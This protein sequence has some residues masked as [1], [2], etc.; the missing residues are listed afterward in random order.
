MKFHLGVLFCFLL[1]DGLSVARATDVDSWSPV[2]DRTLSSQERRRAIEERQ[3]KWPTPVRLSKVA[4][5]QYIDSGDLRTPGFQGIE[6]VI[7]QSEILQ[8]DAAVH[9]AG[10]LVLRELPASHTVLR[11]P[12]LR[13]PKPRQSPYGHPVRGS[14]SIA[15]AEIRSESNHHAGADRHAKFGQTPTVTGRA[16]RFHSPLASDAAQRSLPAPPVHGKHS[17]FGKAG[18]LLK[19]LGPVETKRA[20]IAGAREREVWKQP[21]SYGYFGSSHQRHWTKHHGYRDRYTEWRYR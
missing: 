10:G 6:T 3:I 18:V 21:Y 2:A 19:H 1:V 5:A 20:T 14:E 7:P 9:S 15:G 4:L 13:K 12:R 16:G 11:S 8:G 17:K